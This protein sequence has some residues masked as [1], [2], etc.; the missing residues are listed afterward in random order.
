LT[1]ALGDQAPEL[2]TRLERIETEAQ[3]DW[4]DARPTGNVHGIA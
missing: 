1:K 3:L 2:L 4:L